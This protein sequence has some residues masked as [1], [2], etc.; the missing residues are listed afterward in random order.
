MRA[1]ERGEY[2]ENISCHMGKIFLIYSLTHGRIF[3]HIIK[4]FSTLTK[5][6]AMS[7]GIVE[8]WMGLW[9]G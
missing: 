4:Y 7:H 9:N 6:F 8:G 3:H 1:C 5:Y 2:F